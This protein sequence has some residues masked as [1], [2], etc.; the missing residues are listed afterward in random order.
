MG[1]L[2][3][4]VGGVTD[5]V[6]HTVDGLGEQSGMSLAG[7]VRRLEVQRPA[8]DRPCQARSRFCKSVCE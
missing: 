1:T 3:G 2:G 4:A 7:Q 8:S 5:T 6:G